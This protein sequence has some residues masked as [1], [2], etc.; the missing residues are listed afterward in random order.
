MLFQFCFTSFFTLFCFNLI[1]EEASVM[2]I[3]HCGA[4]DWR[5]DALYCHLCVT[6]APSHPCEPQ[7]GVLGVAAEPARAGSSKTLSRMLGSK[8]LCFSVAF[9]IL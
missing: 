5:V 3:V 1:L 2:D 6:V 7:P 8:S 4:L 9:H